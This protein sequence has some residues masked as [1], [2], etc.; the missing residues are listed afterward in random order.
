M[1]QVA[2]NMQPFTALTSNNI[3]ERIFVRSGFICEMM[4]R[5]YGNRAVTLTVL[6][7]TLNV[8]V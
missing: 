8:K 7:L 5:R 1:A 2:V 3:K 6:Q 4:F